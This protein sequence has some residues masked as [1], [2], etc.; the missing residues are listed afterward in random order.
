[1]SQS[2]LRF[3][4]ASDNTAG[5]A[6]EAAS[7]LMAAS[8]GFSAAYGTDLTTAAAADAVRAWLDADAPVYFLTSGTAANAVCLAALCRPFESVLAHR[9]A[10]TIT[11]EAGAPNFFGQGLA[12]GGLEGA[13]GRIDPQALQGAMSVPHASQRQ[14]PAALSLANSTELGT[15]YSVE[16]MQTLTGLA[17]EQGLAIHLDGARLANA[18]AA[19][20]D[21]RRIRHLG[22]DLLV[23]GGAKLGMPPSEAIVVLNKKLATRFDARLKQGG[24]IPS[25]GRF[26][27]APWLGMLENDRWIEYAAHANAMA[28]RLAARVPFE[29]RYP[30]ETNSIF[31]KMDPTT[32][33]QLRERGWVV[34]RIEEGS[35]RLMC[36]WAST[37]ESVEEFAQAL[38]AVASEIDR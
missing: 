5:L 25:K 26:V 13:Q 24:H 32:Q 6:P 35:V 11:S 1:M 17:R 4:F 20:F 19:G 16:A 28:Q 14:S 34:H 33:G 38:A 8:S 29:I 27:S 9:Y 3:D 37:P 10:H 15:L 36:S 2:A 31:V 7:A 22:I 23:I 30:V 18:V 21:Q 12:I